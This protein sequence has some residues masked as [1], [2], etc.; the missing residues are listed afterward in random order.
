[1]EKEC[2]NYYQ[3]PFLHFSLTKG[4]FLL[5]QGSKQERLCIG[6]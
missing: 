6:G 5:T 3:D 4:K 2:G 1:M